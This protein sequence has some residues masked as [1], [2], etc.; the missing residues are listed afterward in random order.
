MK[1]TIKMKFVGVEVE[2]TGLRIT[3]FTVVCG[4]ALV[5]AL[6]TRLA[7]GI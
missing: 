4:C 5:L 6:A 1:D 3:I 2:I 7:V